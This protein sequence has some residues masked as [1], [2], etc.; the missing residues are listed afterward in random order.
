MNKPKAQQK[1]NLSEVS[2]RDLFQTPNYAVDVLVP[3]LSSVMDGRNGF[4]VWECAAGMGK[5]VRR[6][7]EHGFDVYGSDLDGKEYPKHNFLTQSNGQE[8]HCIVSNPP[9]SLKKRFV[10]QCIRYNV[11]FALLIPADYAGWIIDVV[12]NNGVE[13]IVPNRRVDYITPDILQRIHEGE[14]WEN[15][16]EFYP[17]FKKLSDFKAEC[18]GLWKKE[19]DTYP[20]YCLWDSIY[21]APANLLRKYSSSQF[22]SMWLTWG[23]GLGK[24]ETFVEL[25][26]EEK[27]NI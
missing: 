13:K 27:Y 26:N 5:I 23:F 21:D 2:G 25:T 15:S 19:L 10:V 6:L 3:F 22:H 4:R 8:F 16:K 24:S 17:T 20:D 7:S 9:F 14:V 1:E 12:R 11:P 18:P